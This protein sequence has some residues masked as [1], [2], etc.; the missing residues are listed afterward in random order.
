MTKRI[1]ETQIGEIAIFE[2]KVENT[3][4]VIFLHGVYFDHNL[5]NNQIIQIK[6]R[7][8]IVI[9][10]PLHGESLNNIKL[11]WTLDDCANMLLEILDTLKIKRTFAIGHSWGSMT[12]LRAVNKEPHKFISV[13]FCNMPW[14]SGAKQ[15][16]KFLF[17]HLML[18]FRK[19][20][21]RQASNA[22]FGKTTLKEIPGI[23]NELFVPMSKLTSKNIRQI[24]KAVIVEAD[25]A[26]K[27]LENIE[28]PNLALIG[29]ED[30]LKPPPYLNTR[31]VKGGHISPLEAKEEVMK[32]I[33]ET[34]KLT[35]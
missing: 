33:N 2:K 31:T 17:Q 26:T 14:E 28:V 8:V 35:I 22:L 21:M 5:W 4:P 24:D 30:Y 6:D 19:F 25:D 18:A 12:I 1:I 7:T 23:T 16:T 11:N 27:F 9:D 13:G 32:F 15:K 29:E 34:I 10:M 20:Y 3:N